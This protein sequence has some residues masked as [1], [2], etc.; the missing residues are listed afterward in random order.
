MEDQRKNR[1]V[2]VFFMALGELTKDMTVFREKC[3]TLG[4]AINS[5]LIGLNENVAIRALTQ[6]F[7]A[8][9]Q[10]AVLKEPEQSIGEM[11]DDLAQSVHEHKTKKKGK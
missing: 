3:Y 5:D 7:N 2:G 1:D 6:E 11:V 8:I 9:L 10:K 4:K